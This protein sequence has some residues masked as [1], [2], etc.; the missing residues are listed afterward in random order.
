MIKIR[1]VA[2]IRYGRRYEKNIQM[3]QR[4]ALKASSSSTDRPKVILNDSRREDRSA[5][6]AGFEH[7]T[8][9]ELEVASADRSARTVSDS[10]YVQ[11]CNHIEQELDATKL[12]CPLRRSNHD[13][14]LHYSYKC[15]SIF[16][17][18]KEE[19]G[20]APGSCRRCRA[21]AGLL[22]ESRDA[23]ISLSKGCEENAGGQACHVCA[24]LWL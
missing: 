24:Q 13:L 6:P 17:A 15:K 3:R 8:G 22:L 18:P 9:V 20:G 19:R 11:M 10:T 12:E 21:T 4:S 16:G 14:R 23:R 2:A 5:S 1:W 7:P